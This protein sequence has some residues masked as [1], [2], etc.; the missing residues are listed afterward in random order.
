[1]PN[2]TEWLNCVFRALGDPT[3][4]AV[5]ARLSRGPASVSDLARPFDMALPSF[6]QHLA[7][8]E[9]CGLIRTQKIGRVRTVRLMPQPL[10]A[11]EGWMV[12]QRAL[13]ERRLDQLDD[14]LTHLKER[15]Q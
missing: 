9:N 10:E 1:M 14:Y 15:D 4:R 12:E 13:W 11:A 8:L 2:Q 7:V 5:L 3:R 6:T